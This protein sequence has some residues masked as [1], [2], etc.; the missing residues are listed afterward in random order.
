MRYLEY[1]YIDAVT[2]VSV[3]DAV[4]ANGPTFPD[5]VGLEFVF[6][7]ESVYPTPTPTFYGTCPSNSDINMP[8][9]IAELTKADYAAALEKETADQA[10]IM[11]A[12]TK[13]EYEKAAQDKLDSSA[14]AFGYDSINNAVSYAEEPA[15]PKF[16]NDGKAFRTWRSLVWAYAY[17]VMDAVLAGTQEQPTLDEFLA[18]MPK[19]DL[20]AS[21]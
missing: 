18:D 19:L 15:V 5:V 3:L 8:G 7:L 11:Q 20:P 16:Q 2:G 4:A 9:V 21:A 17:S 12:R 13:A 14:Q 1:T 6:A 10:A